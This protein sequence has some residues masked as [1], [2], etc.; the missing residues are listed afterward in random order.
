MKERKYYH[1]LMPTHVFHSMSSSDK[2]RLI[3]RARH[4]M[5]ITDSVEVEVQLSER[6]ET[7]EKE[8]IVSAIVE[9][10]FTK[11]ISY[12]EDVADSTGRLAFANEALVKRK[13]C[14]R[15]SITM[16]TARGFKLERVRKGAPGGM[17][18]RASA[19]IDTTIMAFEKS[20]VDVFGTR[21]PHLGAP[22][23]EESPKPVEKVKVE[24][25]EIDDLDFLDLKTETPERAEGWGGF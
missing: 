9:P 22:K 14:E 11:P 3:K 25:V 20:E 16:G 10:E 6:L 7:M 2:E 17:R 24:D 15:F 1:Q 23:V 18:L 19:K 12:E 5:G 13:F 4:E 8:I 21:M